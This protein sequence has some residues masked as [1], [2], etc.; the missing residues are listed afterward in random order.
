MDLTLNNLQWLIYHKTK[1]KQTKIEMTQTD[2][3][4]LEKK[5][6]E[7]LP[8]MKAALAH[9]YMELKTTQNNTEKD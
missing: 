6:D 8:A 3:K 5:E 9:Q 7:A 4:Y 2:Y 1:R